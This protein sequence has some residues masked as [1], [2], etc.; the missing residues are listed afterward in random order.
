MTSIVADI[1]IARPPAD[2]FAY[3][4]D[5]SHFPEWQADVVAVRVDGERFTTVRRIAGT[6]R[7]MTQ[8]V[9]ARDAPRTWSVRGVDG[10]VRPHADVTI[11]PLDG[12][13][14]TRAT[15]T[16]DFDGRAMGQTLLPLVRRMT[17]RSAPL[18]LRRLKELLE[19]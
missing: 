14:R 11:E 2:V 17:A 7:S 3:V 16:F 10:P 13:T 15:F 5:P 8:E 9:V 18:S 4:T 1:E 19:A 6:E 12:G